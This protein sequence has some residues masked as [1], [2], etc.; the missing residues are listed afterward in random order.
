V[1]SCC[2]FCLVR[3]RFSTFFESHLVVVFHIFKSL[4]LFWFLRDFL[5]QSS[6]HWLTL[7]TF[8]SYK[9]QRNQSQTK[10]ARG[11]EDS[12]RGY[13]TGEASVIHQSNS[14]LNNNSTDQ[15]NGK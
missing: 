6:Y 15:N 3:R 1:G 5:D 13:P 8:Y 10:R 9:R 14:I 11:R 4:E 12:N 2:D 7:E